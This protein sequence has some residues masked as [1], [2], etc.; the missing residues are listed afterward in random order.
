VT[1]GALS[2]ITGTYSIAA[3]S[4]KV[5]GALVRTLAESQVDLTAR[6]LILGDVFSFEPPNLLQVSKT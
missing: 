1:A 2:T 4:P 6:W 3:S 5:N